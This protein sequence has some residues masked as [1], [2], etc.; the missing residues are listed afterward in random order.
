MGLAETFT[1][2]RAGWVMMTQKHLVFIINSESEHWINDP[3][4][5]HIS[6]ICSL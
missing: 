6:Y 2:A 1:S 4:P 3:R 5:W